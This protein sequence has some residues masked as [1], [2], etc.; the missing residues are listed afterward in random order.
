MRD[1]N[2]HP[3]NIRAAENN[4]LSADWS[5]YTEILW[6]FAV[7]YLANEGLTETSEETRGI[8]MYIFHGK[9]EF[10]RTIRD[11]KKYCDKPIIHALHFTLTAHRSRFVTG[12]ET[13]FQTLF[14]LLDIHPDWE[15]FVDDGGEGVAPRAL[16]IAVEQ[17]IRSYALGPTAKLTMGVG[18]NKVLNKKMY[19]SIL[20]W[21]KVECYITGIRFR[22]GRTSYRKWEDFDWV[23]FV[24]R[25]ALAKTF[26]KRH[27]PLSDGEDHF[28]GELKD[29]PN[30][31]TG[32][33]VHSKEPKKRSSS[34]VQVKV[35]PSDSHRDSAPMKFDPK[36][37]SLVPYVDL[38]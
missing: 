19:A 20:R 23:D 14:D 35:K 26:I 5:N 6:K 37:G 33:S 8:L 24:E 21:R 4:P 34:A 10:G 18:V 7:H 38:S 3:V 30:W 27:L 31:T 25:K 2:D 29:P 32:R 9:Y 11:E 15:N 22:R 12:V 13:H 28:G 16:L 1:N 36:T 17:A